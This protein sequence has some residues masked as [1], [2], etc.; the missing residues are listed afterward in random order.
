V[1]WDDATRVRVLASMKGIYDL[2]L[3]RVAE[4]RKTT[5]DKIAV[6]A[7]GRIFSGIEGKKRGLVDV[8]GGLGA[9]MARA[10]ELGGLPPDGLVRTFTATPKL[11]DVLYGG[12]GPE[13][14]APID[15][16]KLAAPNATSAA[17]AWTREVSPETFVFVQSLEPLTSHERFACA[18]PFA[19]VVR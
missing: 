12:E 17:I 7:E 9:A 13:S 16:S 6:S 4:G 1:A 8:L 11:I 10:K 19:L 2:F 18:V 5:V 15:P 3:T 14:T